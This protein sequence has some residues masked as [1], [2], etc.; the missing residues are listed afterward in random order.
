VGSGAQ[1][2]AAMLPI[3]ASLGFIGTIEIIPALS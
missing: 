1:A 2:S 3:W